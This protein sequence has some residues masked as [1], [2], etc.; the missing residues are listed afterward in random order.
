MTKKRAKATPVKPEIRLHH[1]GPHDGL[2]DIQAAL[3]EADSQEREA[4]KREGREE[5]LIDGQAVVDRTW[6]EWAKQTGTTLPPPRLRRY[7]TIREWISRNVWEPMGRRMPSREEEIGM[8]DRFQPH[9]CAELDKLRKE[10][11]DLIKYHK[12]LAYLWRTRLAPATENPPPDQPGTMQVAA[13]IDELDT[14]ADLPK[15]HM[16]CSDLAA[17]FGVTANA[18]YKRLARWRPLH[19]DG[20][21]EIS[22]RAKNQPAI[23]YRV[24]AVMPTI[25]ALQTKEKC[26]R[27]TAIEKKS[28]NKNSGKSSV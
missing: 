6:Q 4:A 3:L 15:A 2:P 1:G 16:S 21:F 13:H 28:T 7:E 24:Q 27:Q 23:L 9:T 8:C 20:W 11:R 10:R 12:L 22:D 18:L 26:G 25:E 17:R 19:D 14:Q 5:K